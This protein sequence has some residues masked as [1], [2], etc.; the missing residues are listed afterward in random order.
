MTRLEVQESRSESENLITRHYFKTHDL[1]V[2]TGGLKVISERSV[3][4]VRDTF[5]ININQQEG[6]WICRVKHSSDAALRASLNSLLQWSKNAPVEAHI[7]HTASF[8]VRGV[9]EG[10]YGKPWSDSQR[11]KG[12]DYF[13]D[14]NMNHF[15][16]A[17]KDDPW[18]RFDWRVPFKTDFLERISLFQ[19]RALINGISLSIS[20]SPGLTVRYSESED[21]QA[22]LVRYKQLHE[23]GIHHFGLLLDD[24][25]WELQ[26]EED[27]KR[28]STIADAHAH[29]ANEIY[30]KLM[31]LD[32]GIRLSICPLVYRGR[33]TESYIVTLGNGLHPDID[34]MWTGRQ[35]C[36][37][38]LDSFD[39]IKFKENTSKEPF[40]WDNYPVNDAGMIHE[41]HVGPITGRE[42]TLGQYCAGLLA[43][44]MDRFELSLIAIGTIGDYLWD[45]TNYSAEKSWAQVMERLVPVTRDREAISRV[46]R[47]S[48]GSCLAQ[49]QAPEFSQMLDDAKY[50]WRTVSIPAGLK[51]LSDAVEQMKS[52]VETINSLHFSRPD[53]RSEALPWIEKYAQG[54]KAIRGITEILER[55][56]PRKDGRLNAPAGSREKLWK[57]WSSLSEN[58]T[59][60]F[61]DSF[62]L[63]VGELAAEIA[64]E[65]EKEI[66]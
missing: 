64:D 30:S 13:A 14:F 62:I 40:Y 2:P 24:I 3:S 44:P 9:I 28:F 53:W 21:V 50:A 54:E 52:D 4:S 36:S 10:F 55:A 29:Y 15:M 23:L 35:I 42:Q 8:K 45:S 20:L 48:L 41:L 26:H 22:V 19:E 17:P 38:Y 57:I 49:P 25:P 32:D 11:L 47:C 39:A 1:K 65:S 59:R 5:E 18:Q 6:Q 56:T 34:L 7:K 37:E 61:G 16:L 46:F 51:I 66:N 43:N 63:F 31:E 12:L 58:Q 60:L 27:K 33:G